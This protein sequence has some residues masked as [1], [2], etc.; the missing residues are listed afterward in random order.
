MSTSTSDPADAENCEAR[1]NFHRRTV[2]LTGAGISA[3][4]GLPTF[5]DS[6][7]HW[8]RFRP[9]ELATPEAFANNPDRVLEFY[10]TRRK[11]LLDP[12]VR[13]NAAHLAL[14][15]FEKRT[16]SEFLLVTQNVD[17]LHERA[18]H[19]AWSCEL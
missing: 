3:E 8:A 10:A 13:P 12:A 14:A 7:G 17:D 18:I 11:A 19:G 5:R 2:V 1:R 4:S 9:S 16:Q 15:T 6:S